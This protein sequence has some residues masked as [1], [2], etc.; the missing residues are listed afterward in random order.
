MTAQSGPDVA[1][2]LTRCQGP[3]LILE[4]GG[5]TW[6]CTCGEDLAAAWTGNAFDPAPI[7]IIEACAAHQAQVIRE[8]YADW[9]ASSDFAEALH[10]H[11]DGDLLIDGHGPG[12]HIG[13]QV[14][15]AADIVRW[16]RTALTDLLRGQA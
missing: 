13:I 3:F 12:Q 9:I 14:A 15:G 4:I 10:D 7:E 16:A 1:A 6:R 8:A 2:L 5:P 11:I